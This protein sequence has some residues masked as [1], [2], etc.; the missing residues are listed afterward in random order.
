MS[1]NI[2][3]VYDAGPITANDPTDLMYFGRSPYG[4][5]NDNAMLFSDFAIQFGAPYTASA[6]SKTDDTNVTMTLGGSPTIALLAP[7]SMTL[8]WTGQL[9]GARGGTG[10]NNG[11]STFTMGGSVAFMGG[12]TFTGT[13][14]GNTAVT[15]PTSGT[16]ATVSQIPSGAALTKTDDTNVTMTLGGSPT[17]ALVNATSM[18]LGWT[19]V[20]SGTRGGT[21]VNNGASTFTMG[22]SVAFSGAF[23]FNGT[24]TGNTAVTFPTSGTLATTSQLLTS[25]LTTKGDLWGWTSTNAR[26]PVAT[27]DGKVLQVSIGAATG[28]AYSTAAYPATATATGT[29][30]R[31]NG[32]D[33][34]AT[35]AT[36]PSTTTINRILYSSANDV[37][38]QITTANN[39]LLSTNGSGVPGFSA[40]SGFLQTIASQRITATGAFTYTPTT[41]MKYVH[42]RMVGGGGSA[43]GVAASS[44]QTGVSSGGNGGG[45]LEFWMTAAQVGASLSGSV[46]AGGGT[47]TAGNNNGNAGNNTVFGDWTAVG[48]QGGLGGTSSASTQVKLPASD[49]GSNTAGTGTVLMN[50][51]PSRAYTSFTSTT[52]LAVA[53]HGGD[54]L[55]GTGGIG[56]GITGSSSSVGGGAN[57]FGGG[58]GGT[59]AV[60]VAANIAGTQGD[61]GV[62]LIEEYIAI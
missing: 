16:L 35:T 5:T 1:R 28:L 26:L 14:T 52:V 23:T 24:I 33:Y 62:V 51:N 47:T 41:G 17:T 2:K 53:G 61:N 7:A 60:N 40:T 34:V 19:G 46:G 55:L 3:Q 56:P 31:A 11:S 36:Y 30:L 18:T 13:L 15:F 49:A 54:S 45:Y 38:G 12:F 10:V 29:I 50:K 22:G 39:S 9:S 37:I 6:L 21:G 8:G 32:T 57:G 59:A 58:G 20:L 4:L 27:G 44:A 25:P 42:V 43:G 48:G